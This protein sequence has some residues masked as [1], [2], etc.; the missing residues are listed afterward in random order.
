LCT[1]KPNR[2]KKPTSVS[3]DKKNPK[4]YYS[5]NMAEPPDTPATKS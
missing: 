1:M 2:A 5:R 3:H 4:P